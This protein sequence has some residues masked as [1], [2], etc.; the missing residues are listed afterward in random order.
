MTIEQKVHYFDMNSC[1]E[2]MK[3]MM[4][5]GTEGCDCGEMMSHFAGQFEIPAEWQEMMS[6]MG[7]CC[8]A[9]VEENL[10]T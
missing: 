6:K 8:G 5:Q 2:M 4:S 9:D 10:S 1:M 7:S 3:N